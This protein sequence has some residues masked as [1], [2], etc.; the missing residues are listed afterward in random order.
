MARKR[1]KQLSY[2]RSGDIIA[3]ILREWKNCQTEIAYAKMGGMTTQ[4]ILLLVGFGLLITGADFLIT[5]AS[6]TA[7]NFKIPKRIIGFTIMAFG[8]SAPELAISFKALASGN[9]DM[10]LGNVVGSNILN[11]L[12]LVGVAAVIRPL[13]VKVDTIR[14]ELP[15]LLFI[16]IF[17]VILFLDAKLSGGAESVASRGDAIVMILFFL[18]FLYYLITLVKKNSQS[19]AKAVKT[20][21][22]V[23]PAHKLGV[24][25][26]LMV[27]GLA[28]I[29]IGGGLVVDN[30]TD[31]ALAVGVSQ[32]V[33]ALT[34][35]V[36]GASLPDLITTIIASI[37]GEQDLIIGNV[38]GSNIF[39]I[40]IVLGLPVVVFG[41]ISPDSFQILDVAM[42]LVSTVV[43]FICAYNNRRI[44][45]REGAGMLLLFITYY[46]FVIMEGMI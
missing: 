25:L 33:I 16:T 9:T 15:F 34:I 39:N 12:L 38:I 20:K 42:L 23:K 17:L 19:V 2:A 21:K 44:S 1:S 13:R 27:I 8:V 7:Q 28:G 35:V 18:I 46:G 3:Q 37:K 6:S 24:A 43:L 36:F 4:I 41:A 26:L 5:G 30:A 40:C 11:A 10:V 22:A 14:K 32:R 29:V 45:R 31:I